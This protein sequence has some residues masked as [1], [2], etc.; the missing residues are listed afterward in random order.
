M[1][2]PR[3]CLMFHVMFENV[4]FQN[5][6]CQKNQITGRDGVF[7]LLIN[8]SPYSLQ[9]FFEWKFGY[10]PTASVEQRI[11]SSGKSRRSLSF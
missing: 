3:S 6:L 11:K 9:P 8:C 2:I 5:T 1:A 7:F 10:N 4:A